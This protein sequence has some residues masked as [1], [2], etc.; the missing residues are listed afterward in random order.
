M[1]AF[2][3]LVSAGPPVLQAQA[4]QTGQQQQ[5]STDTIRAGRFD[6][7]KM[8]TFEVPPVEYL[9]ETYG[10][11][12]DSAWFAKARLGALRIPGCS[13]SLVSAQGLVMTNHH[14]GREAST[15]V[16]KEGENLLDN[17]FY[18]ATLA[19]E[20]KA[21][22]MYA[23]QL[24]DII[25]VTAEVD[26]AGEDAEAR[27]AKQEE[28]KERILAKRG[29]EEASI[30]VE[31]ISL[32][33]GA[34]TSAYVFKRYEDVRLVMAPELQMGYFGGDPD[35]F[36]YPRYALDMTFF[37]LY[38]EDGQP[39]AT[40]E[41]F[42]W[43]EAGISDGDLVFV[44]GNP[45]S[46]SR[47]ET[48]AQLEFR[49]DVQDV[50][51]LSTLDSRIAVLEQ[52]MTDHP[53]APETVRNDLF[54]LLN[55]QKAYGGIVKGLNDA[56]IMARRRDMERQIRE[57]IAAKPELESEYGEVIDRIAS[58][59]QQKRQ[60]AAGFKAFI[61]LGNPSIDATV[62]VRAFYAAQ[63]LAGKMQGAP[64]DQL[65]EIRTQ[66]F[67]LP[68]QPADLQ[69]ALIAA[70]LRDIETAYGKGNTMVANILQ[71]R[72]PEGTAAIVVQQ[73][74]LADSA[75]TAA[76]LDNGLAMTDPALQLARAIFAAYGPYQQAVQPAAMQEEELARQL[77]RVRFDI[78]GTDIPPD[79]TFS[80]RLADGVVSGYEYNGTVAPPYTTFYGMFDRHF[81]HQEEEWALPER[82]LEAASTMNLTTPI[83][84]VSTADIIGGNSGSPVVDREL[85]VVGLVFDG[86]IEGLPGDY[87][88]LEE[89]ARAVAVDARGILESLRSV[90]KADRLVQ[91]LTGA[92][93][94][95]PPRRDGA[96]SRL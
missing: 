51:L 59:Q 52:Y 74:P 16:T 71:G 10:F 3:G 32:Y 73:S 95:A 30:E 39:L 28:I 2:L 25:D 78:Y 20:R 45:G 14:C 41:Y 12:P 54:S 80:L 17:G 42:R 38:G 60:H 43:S 18:A 8:W 64:E 56:G 15:E 94:S 47:L 92:R 21:D 91:E 36:T 66:I 31:L 69:E 1:T 90:Y 9:R 26:A 5:Q 61:G 63:Y 50:A 19:E 82:W 6:N 49:R 87:I 81:S 34:K 85:R 93:A 55:S 37:R 48:V 7:G 96:K 62:L 86:N 33:A 27:E 11:A 22:N 4:V 89:R 29:G 88:Y 53:D 57:A 65:A 24:I 68:D 58:L 75:K 79:A 77:G 44:I 13:A 76:A 84:F 67:E 35:N 70:R 23:D 40:P 72:S 46:T 83:N